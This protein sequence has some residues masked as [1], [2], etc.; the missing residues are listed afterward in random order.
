MELHGCKR[1]LAWTSASFQVSLNG[2]MAVGISAL[3]KAQMWAEALSIYQDIS[4]SEYRPDWAADLEGGEQEQQQ[5]P[6]QQQQ[7]H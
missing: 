2:A 6:Q 3:V 4:L 5:P 1:D 7:Q